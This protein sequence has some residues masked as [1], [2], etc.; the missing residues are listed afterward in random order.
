MLHYVCPLNC[1]SA[2]HNNNMALRITFN[3]CKTVSTS[4]MALATVN[5]D[6]VIKVTS[7]SSYVY[8]CRFRLSASEMTYIVSSGALNSTH[9]LTCVEAFGCRSPS[10]SI[11]QGMGSLIADNS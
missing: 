1:C 10:Q 6:K 5:I 2:K 8:H 9:S 4:S 11:V 7:V 3:S